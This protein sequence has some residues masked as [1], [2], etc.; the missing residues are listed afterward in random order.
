[1]AGRLSRLLSS[2]HDL[3]YP[4][5]L[6]CICCG[7]IIDYTRIYRLCDDCMSEMKW[8]S[9]RTCA[10]CGKSLSDHNPGE[11]CYNCREHI[12]M[13]DRGYTCTEYGAHERALVFA[14][15]YDGRTDIADT[16]GEIMYDRM[17]AELSAGEL[18]DRYDALVPVPVHP[19]RKSSRGYNQAGLIAASLS[20][21][22][23]IPSDDDLL[24][25]TRETGKM[26]SLTPDQRRENIRGAFAVRK[27]RAGDT[28][29]K[30]FLVIDDIYTTGATVDEIAA[31]LKSERDDNCW[32]P[33]PGAGRVDVLTFAAGADVIKT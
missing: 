32:D 16:I 33:A 19:S 28:A 11:I 12:H 25:R 24:I 18:Q 31:A 29:G 30:A 26:R 23:G 2:A 13:F 10:R 14:L 8:V 6:Y 22:L 17:T 4:G 9:G 5:D 20:R 1:M 7:K 27:R 21:R 3:I 15:K